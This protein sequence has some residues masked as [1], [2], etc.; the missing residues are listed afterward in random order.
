MTLFLYGFFTGGLSLV[1]LYNLQWYINT[2]EKSYLYYTLMQISM[3]LI[4]IRRFNT[5]NN[6]VYFENNLFIFF[7]AIAAIVFALMFTQEFLE[8]KKYFKKIYTFVNLLIVFIIVMAL[9]SLTFDA[10]MIFDLPFSLLFLPFVFLGYLTYKKGL[11]GAKFYIFAW[12]IFVISLIIS[13]IT[14][15]NTQEFIPDIPYVLI[16]NFIQAII[17]SFALSLKTKLLMQEQKEQEQ[18]LIHQSRLASMGEMLVNISHQWRQPL[19]RIASFIMNMQLHIMDNYE[20]EK[21]LLEKLEESQEQLEYMS[22]TIDDFSNFYKTKKEKEE[23]YVSEST[24]NAYTIIKSS[25]VSNNIIIENEIKN[26]FTL[27]SYPKELSQVILNLMQ[28]A[29]DAFIIN[30]IHNPKIIITVDENKIII[31]DNAGGIP[32]DIITKIFEPYFTT[33]DKHDGTGVGLYMSKMILEKNFNAQIS[34]SNQ[35]DGANF[36]IEFL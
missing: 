16:G 23:F 19:N 20:K 14:K 7:S 27:T 28:N 3:V 11:Q 21:Y 5:E 10:L 30:H 29:K 22:S 35:N 13:D 31:Q 6:S 25:L 9:Y 8:L 33:K 15:I 2:K 12:G 36:T 26:D 1:I 18:M 32:T 24:E 17:L 34:V 4:S